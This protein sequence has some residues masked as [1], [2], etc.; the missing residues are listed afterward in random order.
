MSGAPL[1]PNEAELFWRQQLAHNQHRARLI[2]IAG[3]LGLMLFALI[4]LGG[5]SL[6]GRGV[7]AA[8]GRTVLGLGMCAA[9]LLASRRDSTTRLRRFGL[10]SIGIVGVIVAIE[11]YVTWSAG[12]VNNSLG[13]L[14]ITTALYQAPAARPKDAL[15]VA[16]WLALLHA[17]G[18]AATGQP[19]IASLAYLLILNGFLVAMAHQ[20]AGL[21][22]ENFRQRL[23][24]DRMA[25]T[26]SLT[27]LLNHRAFIALLEQR[28]AESEAAGVPLAVAMIDVDHFKKYNDTHGHPS[29]DLVLKALAAW[30]AAAGEAGRLGGEEFAV[31]W[32]GVGPAEATLRAEQ[33][34]ERILA[35]RLPHH[36]SPTSA[37]VTVS[38]GAAVQQPGD[39]DDTAAALLSRADQALYRAKTTG[40]NR[41]CLIPKQQ[42]SQAS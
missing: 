42:Q 35:L 2:A 17:V 24:L 37:W 12:D 40:R 13:L 1:Q 36:A 23:A 15:A 34:A 29:G 39:N 16:L 38:V 20:N 9:L 30:I 28:Q 7:A 19:S 11:D 31:V 27:G 33:L 41:A 6:S 25:R 22:R 4:E 21:E 5:Q 10:A 14:L 26:D 3:A 18:L 8:A 32:P